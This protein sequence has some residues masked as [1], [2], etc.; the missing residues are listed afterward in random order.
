MTEWVRTGGGNSH[1]KWK[2]QKKLNR[3]Q[4]KKKTKYPNRTKRTYQTSTSEEGVGD[5]MVVRLGTG[6]ESDPR[7]PSPG[8]R[9]ESLH[10]PLGRS[11]ERGLLTELSP[12][13]KGNHNKNFFLLY[14]KTFLLTGR[15]QERDYP[16]PSM[17]QRQN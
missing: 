15:A 14:K 9:D 4:L 12:I 8:S 5:P 13:P 10:V 7:S 3:R 11:S 2:A 6:D 1:S 16:T 17:D